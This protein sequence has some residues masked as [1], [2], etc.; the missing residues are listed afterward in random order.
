M[1][2]GNRSPRLTPHGTLKTRKP[3]AFIGQGHRFDLLKWP[4]RALHER[5]PAGGRGFSK[6]T[7]R[8]AG[9]GGASGWSVGPMKVY[10]PLHR[11]SMIR[12]WSPCG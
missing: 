3:R 6:T 11:T 1:S 5:S 2:L 4:K 7:S 10:G 8:V 12:S 9:S